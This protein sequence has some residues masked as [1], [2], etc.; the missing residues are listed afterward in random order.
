MK[1]FLKIFLIVLAVLVVM[2][3]CL[4]LLGDDEPQ[5]SAAAS[6]VEQT[7]SEETWT[8]CLYLCGSDLESEYGLASA[9]FEDIMGASLSENVKVVVET[10]GSSAWFYDIDPSVLQRYCISSEGT[11][12]VDE[13]P[14]ANM[15]KSD[16]LADFLSFCAENYP[17]DHTAVIFWNH[18]GGTLGGVA[19]DELYDYDSLSLTEIHDAFAQVYDL[20]A[21]LPPID[22]MGF[23]AC[24]MGSIDTA[25][26][27]SDI[28]YYLVASEEVE[29]G[30]GWGYT[31]FLNGL[32]R[33]TGMDG[34]TLGK[35]ICDTYQ[36]DCIAEETEDEI[37]LSVIDLQK[38]PALLEAYDAAGVE[39]LGYV[40]DDS[41]F[42]T[43]FARCAEASENY[44]GN[45]ETDGYFDMVDLG[46]LIRNSSELLPET[47]EALLAAL[48]DCVVYK[49]NGPYRTQATGLSC[50]HAY[51]SNYDMYQVYSMYAASKSFDYFYLYSLTGQLPD[52]A[53]S[54][55]GGEAELPAPQETLPGQSDAALLN[56][57]P[58]TLDKD[59]IAVLN[60]G[61]DLAADLSTVLIHIAYVDTEEDI[62]LDL[63]SDSDL[64]GDWETGVFMDNFYGQWG[65][66]DGYL[67]YREVV[68]E[69]DDY[70]LY[71]V[72]ILLNGEACS[73][74]VA[75]SYTDEA[76][77]ILGARPLSS[78][79]GY[80]SDK[81]L[82]LLKP[83]DEIT[84]L[85]Y[86]SSLS[87]DDDLT[88]TPV[89][90]FTVTEDTAFCDVDMGDGDFMLWFVMMDAQ[91][92]SYYSEP[93]YFRITGSEIYVEVE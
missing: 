81:Y 87:G 57:F 22:V 17:A 58:V 90:T 34:A 20:S 29:P 32:S 24:L 65:S 4:A 47:S 62:L 59:G 93:V 2:V 7:D 56:D 10:G 33:D 36:E 78:S 49:V 19:F 92:N 77:S 63:G 80:M 14:L 83:G 21:M 37:T 35:L 86:A 11:A 67:C 16:T 64:S 25:S 71:S 3:G 26:M 75:Y 51:D 84:T 74:S 1:K 88:E 39:A 55:L 54:Y 18:G 28:A 73:L 6:A 48:G 5:P 12:L 27:A 53:A 46:D 89:D 31:S 69:G 44:G 8:V 85:L 76:Y 60:L 9:D 40:C 68:Y 70:T 82:I 79:G 52:D 61:P 45:N 91:N 13:Q 30:N 66:I 42:Y 50:F 43:E 15:G 38:L 41:H 72:P 23:D